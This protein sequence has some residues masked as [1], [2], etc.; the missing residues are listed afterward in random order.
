[1]CSK[2]TFSIYEIF[3]EFVSEYRSR[4]K[5]DAS[6]SNAKRVLDGYW[7]HS[8]KAQLKARYSK[9]LYANPTLRSASIFH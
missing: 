1:M 7:A 5:L 2:R 3:R 8:S 9:V 6:Y 4:R